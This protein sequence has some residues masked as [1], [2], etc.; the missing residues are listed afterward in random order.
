MPIKLGT[1][2]TIGKDYLIYFPKG[3]IVVGNYSGIARKVTFLCGGPID[4]ASVDH[5]TVS[6]FRFKS[7]YPDS[8]FPSGKDKGSIQIGSDC[9]IG[10][11]SMIFGGVAV[12]HGSIVGARAVVTKNV[13]PFSIVAGNPAKIIRYRFEQNIIDQLLEIKWWNWPKEKVEQN[14]ELLADINNF[15]RVHGNKIQ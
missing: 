5:P 9:W 3:Q 8:N 15:L 14:I 11:E 6:N 12:G 2:S 10:T 4:H 1:L 13:P 7:Y